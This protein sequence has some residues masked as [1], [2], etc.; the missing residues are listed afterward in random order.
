MKNL[1]VGERLGV[2]FGL[3]GLLF[4]LVVWQY[5]YTLFGVIKQF[6]TLQ[7]NQ[8]AQKTHFLNV[9]RYMLEARRSEKDFLSRKKLLYPDRVEKYVKL[10]DAETKKI[11][12]IEKR[13]GGRPL[14]DQIH[15]LIQIYH[16][17]FK[18]IVAAWK[19]NGLDHNSGLQGRFRTT[20]HTIE[21]QVKMYIPELE[22]EILTLRR[23]EKDYLLR[24]SSIYVT[25]V[26]QTAAKIIEQINGAGIS[27]ENKKT[28]LAGIKRY[29]DDFLAL[30]EHNNEILKLTANMR[31]AVHKIEP[32]VAI[33]V[34]EATA[35]MNS[36]TD[37]T[38]IQTKERTTAA[39]VVAIIAIILG[40]GFAYY[41]SRS[42]T[43]PVKTITRLAEL[44]A[45]PKSGQETAS[46]DQKDEIMVLTNAMGRM[47]GHL[48]DIIYYIID[49]VAELKKLSETLTNNTNKTIS[50]QDKKMMIGS[51]NQMSE[52]L[53]KK[54]S[55]LDI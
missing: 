23:R 22:E 28:I 50:P 2:G 13:T 36:A 33:G 38:R 10:L 35:Q 3:I 17:D 15:K 19:I 24:G 18:K 44:F 5:H 31:M 14:G 12:A 41:F 7:A 48:R 52:S 32:L 8:A 51:L 49:H 46:P 42:I 34:D 47:T 11:Q 27:D 39:M 53:E 45:P 20:I 4:A 9:H 26:R 43:R 55:Q 25:T 29:E 40:F 1:S 37:R 16:S 54:M 30:V 21:A 6:D